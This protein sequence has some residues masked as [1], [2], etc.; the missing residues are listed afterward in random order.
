MKIATHWNSSSQP[1][2]DETRQSRGRRDHVR[3][4]FLSIIRRRMIGVKP[5]QFQV[6]DPLEMGCQFPM[7]TDML[8]L[9]VEHTLNPGNGFGRVTVLKNCCTDVES[10]RRVIGLFL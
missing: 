9:L 8:G 1:V 6:A 7:S 5:G 2:H 10:Q 3:G 4:S